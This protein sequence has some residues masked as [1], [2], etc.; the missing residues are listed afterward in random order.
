L[1]SNLNGKNH[2]EYIDGS[3]NKLFFIMEPF[4]H[5]FWPLPCPLSAFTRGWV[6]WFS[7][8]NDVCIAA[9]PVRNV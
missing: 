7:D 9:L 5:P 3:L 2:F 4:S 8:Y 6:L 1:L